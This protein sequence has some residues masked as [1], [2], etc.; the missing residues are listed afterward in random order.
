M[1]HVNHVL[2]HTENDPV[3][4]HQR[5]AV[6]SFHSLS[7]KNHIAILL[8]VVIQLYIYIGGMRV[9]RVLIVKTHTDTPY[10]KKETPLSDQNS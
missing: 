9:A 3:L 7:N 2:M 8:E 10:H 5:V 4:P 6:G 1:L